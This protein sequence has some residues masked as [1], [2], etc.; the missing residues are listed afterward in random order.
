MLCGGH[1]GKHKIAIIGGTGFDSIEGFLEKNGAPSYI[2]TPY[3]TVVDPT[4]GHTTAPAV[5]VE[6]GTIEGV[7]GIEF[8]LVKRHGNHHAIPAS[9][10]NHRANAYAALVWGADFSIGITAVGA[11]NPEIKVGDFVVPDELF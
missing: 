5:E 2:T 11:L 7:S 9:Q 6:E 4:A 3:D 1:M 10:V 8:L